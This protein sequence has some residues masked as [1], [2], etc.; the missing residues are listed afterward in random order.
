MAEKINT[1]DDYIAGFDPEV[2][3]ALHELRHFIQS[4]APEAKEKISYGMPAFYLN[5]NLIFF[6]AYKG[7]YSVYPSPSETVEF[8]QE[9]A[10]Y[11]SGKGT[12]RFPMDQPIP[13]DTLR[14]VIQFNVQK[15]RKKMRKK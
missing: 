10:P 6:A 1:I 14:K 5:G 4:E 15:N 8:E 9:L 3:E 2:Q 7:H 13:W 11:R 12:L